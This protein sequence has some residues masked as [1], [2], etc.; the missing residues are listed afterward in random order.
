MTKTKSQRNRKA[1][2]MQQEKEQKTITQ[3]KKVLA[4]KVVAE[5]TVSLAP[6]VKQSVVSE[7]NKKWTNK[8]RVLIFSS[9]GTSFRARHLLTDLRDLTPHSK[10]DVK[11]DRKDQLSIVNE[12]CELKNCNNC[13]FLEMKKKQDL[14]MWLSKTPNGP[15]AKFLVEN[16][17]TM[18]E[19]KL[20]GN[21]LKGSRPILSFDKNFDNEPHWALLK[22]LLL[23]SFGTP[24][25][26][27]KSKPF[28]DRVLSFSIA[29]GRIWFRNY[30]IIKTMGPKR[31]TDTSLVEIGPR[32]CIQPIRVFS[33]SFGGQTLYEN[34]EYRSPNELRS[35]IKNAHS[36]KYKLR[37]NAQAKYDEKV[38]TFDM[39]EDP[40][41]DIFKA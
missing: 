23:H 37:Q 33:G 7:L 4:E 39:P 30:Q 36:E 10:H 14:Y 22:E 34:P 27:P 8:Q 3:A 17:H 25:H 19:L 38:A 24:Y 12:V 21:C 5:T 18:S 35:E 26:H 32:F 28:V 1:V 40:L 41:D 11:L 9:R 31:T 29:D 20:T 6:G 16:V 13:V 15:S 2:A